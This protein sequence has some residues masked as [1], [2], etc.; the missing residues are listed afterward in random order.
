[1]TQPLTIGVNGAAG[2][3]G[4]RIVALVHED[5]DL[6]VAAAL[7]YSGCPHLGQDAGELAGIGAIG[8]PLTSELADRVDKNIDFSLPDDL[9]S[10]ER[11]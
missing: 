1:M 7:E 3:M 5:Q 6:T 11:V 10:I 8:I 4:R 9:V 2:R